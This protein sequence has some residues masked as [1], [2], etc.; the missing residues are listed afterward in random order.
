MRP[1]HCPPEA[2]CSPPLEFL[3]CYKTKKHITFTRRHHTVCCCKWIRHCAKLLVISWQLIISLL[4][5]IL[6]KTCAFTPWNLPILKKYHRF[7]IHNP[8]PNVSTTEHFI[9]TAIL[10]PDSVDGNRV[11]EALRRRLTQEH[12]NMEELSAIRTFLRLVCTKENLGSSERMYKVRC[13][14]LSVWLVCF[15]FG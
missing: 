10:N 15:I 7:I 13:G 6:W 4:I 11:M 8:F 14:L 2:N 1:L 5:S 3:F 9:S 12:Y